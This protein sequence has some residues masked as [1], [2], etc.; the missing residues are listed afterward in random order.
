MVN[1]RI[2]TA[3]VSSNLYPFE[4]RYINIG[5][6]QLHY[7]EEGEGEAVVMLHG[8]PSWSFYYRN[9]IQKL[10]PFYHCLV[11][12]HIGM[13]YSDKPADDTYKYTLSQRVK[14]VEEFLELKGIVQNITLILHDWGGIIGMSFACRHP[15]AIKK[16]IILNTSAFHLPK[17]KRFPLFLNFT[18]TALGE[19]FLRA[20]NSF[21]IGA[22]RIGVRRTKMSSDVRKA[23]TAPYNS[24][25]NRIGILRFVQDIPLKKNDPAFDLVSDVQNNLHLFSNTP[26]LIAWGMKDKV[27]DE[28]FLNKWLDYLPHAK[29]HRF[30]D[31]GHYVLED[32]Q[33]EIGKLVVDFLTK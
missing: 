10:S 22:T 5:G 14:D 16:I 3:K 30:E 12:D 4:H 29:V 9:L 25:K 20:F 23:Y 8:N 2:N 1:K 21:S 13:G 31:C 19:F 26:V 33:E 27:F 17:G 11:P 6:H 15:Q 28:F 18:R 32:A 7:I 24:W